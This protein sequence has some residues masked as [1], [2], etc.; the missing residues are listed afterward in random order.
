M[1]LPQVGRVSIGV[2]A[3]VRNGVELHKARLRTLAGQQRLV[4]PKNAQVV[5]GQ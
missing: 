3:R 4:S 5:E 1:G 2:V